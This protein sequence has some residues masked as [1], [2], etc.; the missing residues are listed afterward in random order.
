MKFN[1]SL[2]TVFILSILAGV[3]SVSLADEMSGMA[4]STP[5][6]SQPMAQTTP[7][8]EKI[9]K[10]AKKKA[11]SKVVWVCPMGDYSG[12]RTKDGKCPKC[13]MDLVKSKAPVGTAPSSTPDAMNSH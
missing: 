10:K 13:G 2:I 11:A 3:S 6:A 1:F 7:T 8:T 5:A 4:M 12:P 9:A